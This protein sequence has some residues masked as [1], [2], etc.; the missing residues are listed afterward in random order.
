MTD[1]DYAE[2]KSY[3]RT[4]GWALASLP[5]RDRDD[6]VEETRLH[7]LARIEQGHGLAQA[8]EALGPPQTYARGFVEEMETASA[9]GSR[10]WPAL[11]S[12]VARR[13]H[14]SAAAALALAIVVLL[15]A[16]ALP[17]AHLAVLKL[18]D[19]AHVG[20]WSG[21]GDQFFIGV[22]DDP[23]S[24]RELLGLWIFPLAVAALVFA[25]WVGRA[26]LAWALRTALR[27]G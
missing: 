19:P 20:L 14:K 6:I 8:L 27:A 21:P 7:V 23:S 24:S 2:L 25:W 22:I 9:L 1:K 10:R 12:V 15:A 4:L 17:L 3:L 13:V 16:V 5:E 18:L 11:L 26:V